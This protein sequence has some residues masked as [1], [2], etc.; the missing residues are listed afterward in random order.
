[1]DFLDP[2][3]KKRRTRRLLLGYGLVAT[4]I[5]MIA[6]ILVYAAYGFNLDRKTGEV[7]HNGLLYVDSAP[8][9]AKVELKNVNSNFNLSDQTNT[10]LTVPDG[11]YNVKISKNG[12]RDWNRKMNILGGT[13][14]RLTYPL[15]I[16]KDLKQTKIADFGPTSPVFVTSS[17][18]RRWIVKAET[19]TPF[20]VNVFDLKSIDKN[21]KIPKNTK[22]TLPNILKPADGA[23]SFEVVEWSTDNKNFLVKHVYGSGHEFIIINREQPTESINL[24][25]LSGL[26]PSKVNLKDKDPAKWY[27]YSDKDLNLT[28]TNR[29]KETVVIKNQITSYTSHGDDTL[30]YAQKSSDT[31]QKVFIRKNN[32]EKLVGKFK[33]GVIGLKI[34]EFDNNWYLAVSSSGDDKTFIYENPQKSQPSLTD[35]A[36]LKPIISLGFADSSANPNFSANS[37]FILISNAQKL[38]VFD[39]EKIETFAFDIGD[40][41]NPTNFKPKWMD[42]HRIIY[43]TIDG[44]LKIVDFDNNNKQPLVGADSTDHV[45]FDRDYTVMY[46][47]S[48]NPA[49]PTT[50]SSYSLNYTDL[51]LDSDK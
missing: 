4:M 41:I 25:D 16:M 34:T 8:D 47:V 49:T 17:P 19:V 43:S 30:V 6:S 28:Q 50:P 1:M 7:V 3:Y 44:T 11:E 37:R 22:L 2:E 27:F 29:K 23:E 13:V 18:D 35:L 32:E 20:V 21:Q 39:A 48:N 15:L 36:S 51:R 31:E 24:N 38:G 12:Y 45:Y 5:F 46:T 26:S 42:G 14:Y 33:S 10:K 9:K 40:S